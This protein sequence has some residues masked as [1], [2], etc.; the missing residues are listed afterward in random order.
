VQD[1]TGRCDMPD[2]MGPAIIAG[3]PVISAVKFG[4]P[5]MRTAV[6][7]ARAFWPFNVPENMTEFS[8]A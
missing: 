1:R 6:T 3:F 4:D 8:D 5:F 7:E 2:I